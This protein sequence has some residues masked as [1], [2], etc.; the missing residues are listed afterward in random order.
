M[1]FWDTLG[2]LLGTAWASS[3]VWFAR[4]F[5]VMTFIRKASK[6]A[7]DDLDDATRDVLARRLLSIDG[8]RTSSWLPDFTRVFDRFFGEKHFRWRCFY[9]S[10][11]ISVIT[12]TLLLYIATNFFI[13]SEGPVSLSQIFYFV[14]LFGLLINGIADYFSLLETRMLLNSRYST[15][16]KIVVDLVLT[17]FLT[18]FW[19]AL[20]F[21][22]LGWNEVFYKIVTTI[23]ND[24]IGIT[25]SGGKE[26]KILMVIIFTGYLTSIWLWLHGLAQLAIYVVRKFGWVVNFLNVRQK[27]LRALGLT[28][29]I[30]RAYSKTLTH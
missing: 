12:I 20:V 11:L 17:F 10:M 19:F 3:V 5:A 6:D 18:I 4:V 29:N 27:P 30:F 26:L 23:W 2:G 9:R 28:M 24:F 8:S 15:S 22:L 1:T 16:V 25:H 13:T 7:D 14:F 21:H